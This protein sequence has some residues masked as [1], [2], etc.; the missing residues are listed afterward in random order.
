MNTIECS[1]GPCQKFITPMENLNDYDFEPINSNS[2]LIDIDAYQQGQ[3]SRT[4]CATNAWKNIT[5]LNLAAQFS[6]VEESLIRQWDEVIE[7]L[8][9]M[10][11][12]PNECM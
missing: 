5:S 1:K 3:V 7:D 6:W 9:D 2:C 10:E 4:I 11:E 8:I 12:K